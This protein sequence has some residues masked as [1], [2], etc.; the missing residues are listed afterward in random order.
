MQSKVL[1]QQELG[2]IEQPLEQA[3]PQKPQ[4]LQKRS[5]IAGA[6]VIAHA[7]PIR[8]IV[9]P[10]V[11]RSADRI[12]FQENFIIGFSPYWATF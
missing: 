1:V 12:L 10:S 6:G 2:L 9:R 7:I 8:T 5:V 3:L 11:I 4:D